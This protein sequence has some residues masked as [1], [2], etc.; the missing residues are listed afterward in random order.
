MTQNPPS[1]SEPQQAT[2]PISHNLE[3]QA[4]DLVTL[5]QVRSALAKIPGSLVDDFLRERDDRI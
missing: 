5:S 4:D 2:A 1:R 3:S